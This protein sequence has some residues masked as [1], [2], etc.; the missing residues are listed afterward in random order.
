MTIHLGPTVK[1]AATWFALAGL[2][3]AVL[4]LFAMGMA[5]LLAAIPVSI[6]A[7]SITAVALAR[8]LAGIYAAPL[9]RAVRTQAALLGVVV[10]L[11]CV[12]GGTLTGA[13]VQVGIDLARDRILISSPGD[14]PELLFASL[15]WVLYVG[16]VP[17]VLLG[18]AFGLLVRR[19]ARQANESA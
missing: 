4:M 1:S 8:R 16:L 10:A 9:Q 5:H 13:L 19:K 14:V 2:A 3:L 17:A 6:A 18:S 15:V 11:G 12:I 7:G